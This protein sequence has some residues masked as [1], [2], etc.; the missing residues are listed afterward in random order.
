MLLPN[1]GVIEFEVVDD[2]VHPSCSALL[3]LAA[4]AAQAQNEAGSDAGSGDGWSFA[5]AASLAPPP[6]AVPLG[7]LPYVGVPPARLLAAIKRAHLR[8]PVGCWERHAAAYH[9]LLRL[10]AADT[11]ATLSPSEAA[12]AARRAAE[13]EARYPDP[14]AKLSLGTKSNGEFLEPGGVPFR[15]DQPFTHDELH[16][17]VAA[18]GALPVYLTLKDDAQRAAVPAQNFEAASLETRLRCMREEVMAIALERHTMP[19]LLD[20]RREPDPSEVAYSKALMHVSTAL[21]KGVYRDFML[22]HYPQLRVPPQDFVGAFRATWA[23]RFP[24][25]V[26]GAPPAPA[27]CRAEVSMKALAGGVGALQLGGV[28]ASPEIGSADADSDIDAADIRDT[29]LRLVLGQTESLAADGLTRTLLI[30][31]CVCSDWR[32][33]LAPPEVWQACALAAW[34]V[35]VGAG[36]AREYCAFRSGL[37]GSP[38]NLVAASAG[39]EACF[40]AWFARDI[41]KGSGRAKAALAASSEV[42]R[43]ATILEQ[44]ARFHSHKI[45]IKNGFAEGSERPFMEGLVDAFELKRDDETDDRT[46]RSVEFAVFGAGEWAGQHDTI[47]LDTLVHK[48][49]E[50]SQNFIETS[51]VVESLKFGCIVALSTTESSSSFDCELDLAVN[52]AHFQPLKDLWK[53]I[54]PPALGGDENDTAAVLDVAFQ[55]QKIMVPYVPNEV[56]EALD[57]K[58]M[59]FFIILRKYAS[60]KKEVFLEADDSDSDGGS[61]GSDDYSDDSDSDGGSDGSDDYIEIE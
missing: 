46:T 6:L 54:S 1:A 60:D 40:A 19:A 36:E 61:D 10:A 37:D 50:Y 13:A 34:G 55:L 18:P 29:A 17:L 52:D 35:K 28:V 12:F 2:E 11:A 30:A 42:E 53:F 14:S 23:A 15:R 47:T 58:G 45:G 21:T 9:A 8:F 25:S 26:G 41:A 39:L 43:R 31:S 3:A 22:D 20:G 38:D 57:S 27:P 49:Q 51:M 5:D 4:R 59:C 48:Y 56:G 33:T 44:H 7:A 16:E 32:R 24:A